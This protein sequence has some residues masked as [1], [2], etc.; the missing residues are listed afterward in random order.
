MSEMLPKKKPSVFDDNEVR[1]NF[2]FLRHIAYTPSHV[3][4]PPTA[5][6]F[7]PPDAFLAS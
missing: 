7:I 5:P 3:N 1:T 2:V 4:F 6:R